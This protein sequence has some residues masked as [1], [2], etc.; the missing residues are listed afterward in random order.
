M[1]IEIKNLVA[2]VVSMLIQWTEVLFFISRNFFVSDYVN[3]E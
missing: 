3:R 2:A 1:Q